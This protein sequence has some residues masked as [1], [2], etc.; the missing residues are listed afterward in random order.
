MSKTDRPPQRT[1]EVYEEADS[2]LPALKLPEPCE[3]RVEIHNDYVILYVGQR[4]WRWNRKTGM[5]SGCGT[6]FDHPIP[7]ESEPTL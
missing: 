7:D 5:L 6:A 3:V 1:Y 2:I 4:D